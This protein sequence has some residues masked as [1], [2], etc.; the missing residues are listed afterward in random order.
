MLSPK[1]R[2]HGVIINSSLYFRGSPSWLHRRVTGVLLR[3]A[4]SPAPPQTDSVGLR[5]EPGHQ[6]CVMPASRSPTQTPGPV[7]LI[8]LAF[9]NSVPFF[10]SLHSNYL[11]FSTGL[12]RWSLQPRSSPF[13]IVPLLPE[14]FFPNAQQISSRP[15]PSSLPPVSYASTRTRYC[16]PSRRLSSW[17]WRHF[18]LCSLGDCINICSGELLNIKLHQ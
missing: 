8:S 18:S 13:A 17:T 10:P 4:M 5:V 6:V 12:W 16:S 1:A 15:L 9:L 2:T 3:T 11:R 7:A 14:W